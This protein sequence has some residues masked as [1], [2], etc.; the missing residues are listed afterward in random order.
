MPFDVE[1]ALAKVLEREMRLARD[2]ERLKQELE[3]RYDYSA[4]VLYHVID[5]INYGFID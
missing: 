3:T 2:L 1:S 4:K 5:D